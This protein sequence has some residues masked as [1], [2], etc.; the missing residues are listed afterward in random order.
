LS[1]NLRTR[2]DTLLKKFIT[3]LESNGSTDEQKVE[4]IDTVIKR[5]QEHKS[6]PRYGTIIA[7]ME[8]VLME[9]RVEYDTGLGEL[10][11]IFLDF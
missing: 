3:R 4:A 9:Y 11:E 10:E 8:K 6:N 1:K 7:Y 5:L 2:I